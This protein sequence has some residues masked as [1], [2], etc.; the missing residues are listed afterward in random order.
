MKKSFTL[1]LLFECLAFLSRAQTRFEYIGHHVLTPNAIDTTGVFCRTFYHEGR[2]KYY[3]I[4]AG[5]ADYLSNQHYAWRE[6]DFDFNVPTNSGTLAG[7][8]TASVGDFAMVMVGTNY[9]HLTGASN[10]WSYQLSKYDED[11]NLL[12]SVTFP[13]D[14]TDSKADMMLNYTNGRL[15]IGAFHQEGVLHPTM[16]QQSAGWEPILHKW[17]YDL[18]LNELTPPAYLNEVFTPWG[19]SCIFNNNT[20]HIVSFDKWKGPTNPVFKLQ[21]YRYDASWNFIDSIPLNNDGQW[22]QGLLWDGSN[23]L[24]AYHSGHSH[25]AGNITL[26]AY[27]SNWN[28]VYDTVITNYSNFEQFSSPPLFTTDYNANRPFLTLVND[29]LIVSYDVDAYRLQN[30]N[31]F[32]LHDNAWQ[33]HVMKFK[34]NRYAGLPGFQSAEKQSLHPNPSSGKTQITFEHETSPNSLFELFHSDGRLLLQRDVSLQK[35]IEFDCSTLEKASYYYR[36]TTNEGLFS[37]QLIVN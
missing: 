34:I 31:G 25:Q 19:S 6:Y 17:E 15:I 2:N 12:S 20:Y 36:L 8:N 32:F 16:P 28:L 1:L 11:F 7:F 9:Y 37:G 27:D 23:Y 18:M 14:S 24:M 10:A 35:S 33:A 4:F 21:V 30:W 29:T 5:R 13:I 3:T 26:A 22:S